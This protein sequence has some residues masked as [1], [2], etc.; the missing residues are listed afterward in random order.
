MK[1]NWLDVCTDQSNEEHLKIFCFKLDIAI[2]NSCQNNNNRCHSR[3]LYI[4]IAIP[5]SLG[6]E[7]PPG[8]KKITMIAI[9]ALSAVKAVLDSNSKHY[10]T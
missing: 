1:T 4:I 7:V 3:R 8:N 9:I 6:N 2:H 10:T 5:K